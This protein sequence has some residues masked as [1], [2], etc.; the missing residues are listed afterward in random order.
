MLA[1]DSH[2]RV[3]NRKWR[4]RDA[5][6]NVLSF[7]A[8]AHQFGGALPRMLG[9]IIIA[10]ETT[11]REAA[12][13]RKAFADH[14]AHLCVHG[15]LHLLGYDHVC[16]EDAAAMEQIETTILRRLRIPDPY[17]ERA[18]TAVSKCH[19]GSRSIQRH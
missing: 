18:A 8:L 1:G 6:T 17:T 15:F 2:I 14:V 16:A 4:N 13:Q 10:Y 7:P 11:Q 5:P 9:D 12:A 19:A 3:L